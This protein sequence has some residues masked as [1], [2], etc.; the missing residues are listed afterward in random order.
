MILI[1]IKLIVII[2]IIIMIAT[3]I[4]TMKIRTLIIV[5]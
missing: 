2:I 1:V 5:I 4:L 3:P